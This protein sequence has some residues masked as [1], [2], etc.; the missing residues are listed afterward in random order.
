MP[1]PRFRRL[2]KIFKGEGHVLESRDPAELAEKVLGLKTQSDDLDSEMEPSTEEPLEQREPEEVQEAI[3]EE[4]EEE[5]IPKVV[6]KALERISAGDEDLADNFTRAEMEEI[7][8][9][10]EVENPSDLPN[11]S[12]LNKAILDAVK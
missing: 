2:R 1:T 12:A 11:K 10:F 8:S 4:Q 3:V 5:Q 9:H 7:A 6:S